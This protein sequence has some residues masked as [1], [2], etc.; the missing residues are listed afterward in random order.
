MDMNVLVNSFTY[1]NKCN[2]SHIGGVV[3]SS[4]GMWGEF[5]TWARGSVKCAGSSAAGAR[6]R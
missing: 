5:V 1:Y 3:A 6:F 2:S 4:V